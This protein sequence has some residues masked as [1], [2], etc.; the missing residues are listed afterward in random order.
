MPTLKTRTVVIDCKTCN[1][2]QPHAIEPA[3]SN[4]LRFRTLRCIGCSHANGYE[5][6]TVAKGGK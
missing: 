1:M 2:R 5:F 6:D 4:D 3:H